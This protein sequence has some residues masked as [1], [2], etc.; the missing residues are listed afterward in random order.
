MDYKRNAT[1]RKKVKELVKHRG[2][3]IKKTVPNGKRRTGK[4]TRLCQKNEQKA[5]IIR[6]IK[7]IFYQ[8]FPRLKE[9][10]AFYVR[11][12]RPWMVKR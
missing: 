7:G 4:Q 6:D 8:E 11:A 3:S 2:Q 1:K 5:K 10:Q 9:A 12:K